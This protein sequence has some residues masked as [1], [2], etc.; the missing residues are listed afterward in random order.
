MKKAMIV[1]AI[2]FALTII[3]PVIV[4]FTDTGK[5]DGSELVGI[6][7]QCITLIEYYH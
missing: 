2:I 5:S 1:Y 7:R 4:C 3:V 6:F